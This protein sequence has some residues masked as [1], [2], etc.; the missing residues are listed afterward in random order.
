LDCP[1]NS[2]WQAKT[3]KCR[4][5]WNLCA[6]FDPN[7]HQAVIFAQDSS[8]EELREK[9]YSYL[10]ASIGSIFVARRPGR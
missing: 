3:L 7:Y 10:S 8:E 6:R 5:H 4:K 9:G 2:F 1:L